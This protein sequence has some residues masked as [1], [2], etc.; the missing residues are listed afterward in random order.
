M[1]DRINMLFVALETDIREDDVQTL[2]SAIRQ[3]RR[4]I[5]VKTHVHEPS[6]WLAQERVRREM[7][8]KIWDIIK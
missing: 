8:E 6:D 7:K 5:A 4:V 3:L 2:V 1:T